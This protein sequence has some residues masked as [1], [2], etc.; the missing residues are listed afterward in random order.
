[1][2]KQITPDWVD[3]IKLNIQRGCD[4]DGIFKILLD[5]GFS[6]DQIVT[7]MNYEPVVDPAYITNPLAE[8]LQREIIQDGEAFSRKVALSTAK[9]YLPNAQKIATDL[10]EFYLLEDFL[11]Q[12]ECERLTT[13]IKSRL[14]ASEIAETDDEDSSFRTS[15]TCDLGYMTDSFTQDIDR[16]ICKMIGIDASYSEV[17]QGQY[18]QVGQEFKAHTDYFE[19]DQFQRYAAT[20]GQRT[21]TFFIYLNDVEEGGET[22]F[23]KL[24]L[25]IKAQRGRALIWNNLTA[26]G[27]P[28]P[29]TIHQAH[30]VL[31][32]HK[33]V[34][35]K[36]FRANGIGPMYTKEP[37]EFIPNLTKEGFKTS[38]LDP[39]L[40]D[41][42]AEFYRQ[43]REHSHEE[44]VEGGFIYS[45][46]PS[47]R[48][49]T[50]V[51]LPE[52]IRAEI[53]AS[54]SRE[55]S[56]WSGVNLTPTYV[57]GIRTYHRGAILN[58][59]RDRLQTHIISAIINVDQIADSPWPL[60]IED[61]HYRRHHI[62]L[63]PG[64]VL[65][66]EGARLAHGRPEAFDGTRFANI[67]CHYMPA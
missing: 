32:G 48:A 34:I 49:S 15:R 59:H 55:L 19:T 65:Y 53:H 36:W 67:F 43:N 13:L 58:T 56:E 17:I 33:C 16:R 1:M 45:E 6:R 37:N 25:R 21:Y 41:E 50:V 26:Q 46:E 31:K 51:E 24:G 57:Y 14:R 22:E 52:E 54:L 27:V 10:G 44:R 5:E 42:L 11:N 9:I 3:W 39:E 8:R 30:P 62:Y 61:N 40:Y 35:T 4:K 23:L 20:R 66:Y 47:S 29:N 63:Q 2:G 64:E 12:Q 38:R 7:Q 18:Y 28:N 60:L